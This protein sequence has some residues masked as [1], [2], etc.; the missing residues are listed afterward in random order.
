MQHWGEGLEYDD[1][2]QEGSIAVWGQLIKGGPVTR[3]VV[4]FRCLK[5][6]SYL[7]RQIPEDYDNMLPLPSE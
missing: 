1:L 7:R 5:Y 3:D 4:F 6:I 2:F